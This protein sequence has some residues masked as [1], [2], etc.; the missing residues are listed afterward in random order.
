[1][2]GG[3]PRLEGPVSGEAIGGKLKHGGWEVVP[4]VVEEALEIGHRGCGPSP[5]VLL[6]V[7]KRELVREAGGGV[8]VGEDPPRFAEEG[9]G[10]GGIF[11]VE[12]GV[13]G[14]EH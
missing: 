2:V 3:G 4:L 10:T 11:G 12:G 14:A 5:V 1:M 6:V 9:E 13:E 8:G 7:C